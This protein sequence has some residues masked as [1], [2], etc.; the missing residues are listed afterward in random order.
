MKDFNFNALQCSNLKPQNILLHYL[1]STV[2]LMYGS[3]FGLF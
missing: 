1:C 3:E 2:H